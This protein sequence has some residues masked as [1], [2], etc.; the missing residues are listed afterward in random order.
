MRSQGFRPAKLLP[1][2]WI[3]D[4][5]EDGL[6]NILQYLDNFLV[7]LTCQQA[8]SQFRTAISKRFNVEWQERADWYLQA[9]ISQDSHQNI[10]INQCQYA[11]AII[12]CYLP[13]TDP[14]TEDAMEKYKTPLP[15][16]FVWT[17][18]DCSDSPLK[19][20]ELEDKFGFKMRTVIG[21]L[22]YLANTAFEELYAICKA[23]RYMHLPGRKHFVAVRH[24]LHHLRC[25]P[26]KAIKYYHDSRNSPLYEHLKENSLKH[27]DPWFI[28]MSDSLFANA[29]G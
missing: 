18:A 20:Q 13:Y 8:K 27:L 26:P 28:A 16:S 7:A 14:P 11:I 25:H 10:S 1:A 23:C 15:K 29:D 6:V 17:V 3:K 9:R 2:I 22:N 5:N 12:D 21:S 4:L 24:L 19:V